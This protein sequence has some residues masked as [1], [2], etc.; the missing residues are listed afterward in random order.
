MLS[1][2]ITVNGGTPAARRL[3]SAS[4]MNPNT[5]TGTAPGSRSA[6]SPGS[7]VSSSPVTWFTLYPPSVIVSDTIRVA[8]STIR[9]RTAFGSSGANR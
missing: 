3:A 6:A 5:L 1:H 8:G 7:E 4:T 9:S 2:D